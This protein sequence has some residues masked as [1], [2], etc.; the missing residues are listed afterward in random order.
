MDRIA[1]FIHAVELRMEQHLVDCE[2]RRDGFVSSDLDAVRGTLVAL[3]E[4]SELD[5]R[6][7]CEWGSAMGGVAGVA[8]AVGFEAYGIELQSALVDGARAVTS[9][10]GWNAT[11]A[12]GTFV[13]ESAR[14]W[15]LSSEYVWW[16]DRLPP[17]YEELGIDLDDCDVVYAYPWPGEEEVVD[18]IFT[19]EAHERA[20]LVTNHGSSGF[21]WARRAADGDGLEVLRWC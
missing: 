20:I 10:F 9:E 19:A 5:G 4:S 14:E 8:A 11:F 1:D 3:L 18:A 16:D 15:T 12:V 13:P 6:V 7:F 21:R 17:G 2:D